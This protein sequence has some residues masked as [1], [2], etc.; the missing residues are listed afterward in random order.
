LSYSYY[1]HIGDASGAWSTADTLPSVSPAGNQCR[2]VLLD[3]D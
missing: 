1:E 2:F 3:E